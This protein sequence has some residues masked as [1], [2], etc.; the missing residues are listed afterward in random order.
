VAKAALELLILLSPSPQCCITGLCHHIWFYF[1]QRIEP[2][3]VS[4]WQEFY[5]LNY[6]PSLL[7]QGHSKA[8]AKK[9]SSNA[10]WRWFSVGG[11]QTQA[12]HLVNAQGFKNDLF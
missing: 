5:P 12:P 2:K 9:A 3:A 6:I 7:G 1:V 4:A 8:H 10:K 11:I